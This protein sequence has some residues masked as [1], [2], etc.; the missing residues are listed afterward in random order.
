MRESG[1]T[2]DLVGRAAAGDT[3]A[4]QAL[5]SLYQ[6]RLKSMIRL[7][8]HNGLRRRLDPSDILQEAYLEAAK[9]M[10]ARLEDPPQSFFL[11]LRKITVNKLAEVHRRHLDVQ[12]RDLG[13][14]ISIVG[15][16]APMA[17]STS[18]AARLLGR[19]STPS[20][21]AMKAEARMQLQQVLESLDP[22]DREV[23]ALRHFEQLNSEETAA[24]LGM[25]KSGAS[26]RYVRAMRRLHAALSEIAG[27]DSSV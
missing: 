12:A 7:R 1:E 13:R 10:D 23:I 16:D 19:I 8:M 9:H 2:N 17:N 14:E 5:F 20:Q 3:S 22:I 25:S 15:H 18:L 26:S 6:N 24:V 4:R 27:L 11:W 21:I